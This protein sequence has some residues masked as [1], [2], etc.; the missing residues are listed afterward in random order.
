MLAL[1]RSRGL[2]AAGA[3][4]RLFPVEVQPWAASAAE[5]A[6]APVW[7]DGPGSLHPLA[8]PGIDAALQARQFDIER[9]FDGIEPW[10]RQL[11]ADA[12]ARGAFEPALES[13]A[14]RFSLRFADAPTSFNWAAPLPWPRLYAHAV[15]AAF[16]ALAHRRL[17]HAALAR[18]E[19]EAVEE[20]VGRWGFHA[21]DIAPCADGRLAG[22]TE[23]ILRIPR[24]VLHARRSFA[25]AM[26]DL[27]QAIDDWRAAELARLGRGAAA[28]APTR[29]LKI[30]VYHFSASDPR[31]EGCA[32]HGSDTHRAQSA[33]LERL[34]QFQGAIAALHGRE[35]ALLLVGVDTDDD[36]IRVHVP[37]ADGR[38]AIER[39]VDSAALLE[40]TRALPRA[41]AKELIREQ[42]AACADVAADDA[43]TEGMR[44]FC[45]YLLKN[46]LGRVDALRRQT[47]ARAHAELGH[48]E[49]LIVAGDPIDEVQLRNLAFQ[50]QFTTFEEG[51]ADLAVGYSLLAHRHA[52]RALAVPVLA[53]ARCD[54]RVPGS[55]QR[56]AERALRHARAIWRGLSARTAAQGELV[57][58]AATID[59]QGAIAFVTEPHLDGA[60]EL[61]L[62]ERG[63]QAS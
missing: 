33:L 14:E 40:L 19:G 50:T 31:H 7:A 35:V 11:A 63:C 62:N 44:W 45:G 42:V 26:F 46:N 43:A 21:V 13:M 37:D 34:R 1:A 47:A 60:R 58:R 25:G 57:V 29:L 53:C 8:E 10:L 15:L 30:G 41:A 3:R 56:A 27:D 48:A 12:A 54:A 16:V 9:S 20:L 39:A 49:R 36:S 59:A 32:A 23:H 17:D 55:R 2:A 52:P 5:A 51:A 4:R 22:L 28:D 6:A 61:G 38:I 24:A 18:H